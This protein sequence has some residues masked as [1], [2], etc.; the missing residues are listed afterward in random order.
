MMV[1]GSMVKSQEAAKLFPKEK[2]N[3]K[4]N[5]KEAIKMALENNILRMETIMRVII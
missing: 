5:F 3:F 4:E 1:I 2:Y